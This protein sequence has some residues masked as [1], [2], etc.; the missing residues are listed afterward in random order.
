MNPSSAP[1]YSNEFELPLQGC[2]RR[3]R[4]RMPE[5]GEALLLWFPP[6]TRTPSRAAT[7]FPA[8]IEVFVDTVDGSDIDRPTAREVLADPR[9]MGAYLAAR[10]RLLHFGSE[11]GRIH[12]QC[13]HCRDWEAE[14]EP[15]ALAVGL[16]A[17]FWPVVDADQCLAVPAWANAV[18]LPMRDPRL[19][20]TSRLRFT[21][22]S[23]TLGIE[24]PA[25]AAVL[26]ERDVS[27]LEAHIETQLKRMRSE[28]PELY[29]DWDPGFPGVQALI[30]ACAALERLDEVEAS[31]DTVAAL[32]LCDFLFLD[33]AYH[34]TH[35]VPVPTDTSLL[36]K[37]GGCGGRFLPVR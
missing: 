1:S 9:S 14:L 32:P 10:N 28:Q 29:D 17:E 15:I 6:A 22:P 5:F 24:S 27:S 30:R 8:E 37:C 12:A 26:R 11:P 16:H 3:A 21:L 4:L 18:E 23:A 33:N 20:L 31:L 13:P 25:R 19:A 36:L 34:L 2:P 7:F 35:R